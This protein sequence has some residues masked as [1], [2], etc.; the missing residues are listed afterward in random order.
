MGGLRGYVLLNEFGGNSDHRSFNQHGTTTVGF[1]GW[2][3][4]QYH[5]P[6]DVPGIVH[7]DGLALTVEIVLQILV[8]QGGH[9][10]IEEPLI[11]I[12]ESWVFPFVLALLAGLE[13]GLAV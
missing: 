8:A 9:E 1:Y 12:S 4:E 5:R 13:L 3:Y 2:E 11:Q 10:S 7:Q 6:T